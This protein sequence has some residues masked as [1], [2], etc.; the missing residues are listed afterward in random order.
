M[1]PKNINSPPFNKRIPVSLNLFNPF[2]ALDFPGVH[3]VGP[4]PGLKE[5]PVLF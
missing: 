4:V 2:A 1:M 5:F 3:R